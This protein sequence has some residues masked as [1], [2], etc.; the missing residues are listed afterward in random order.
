MLRCRLFPGR[1]HLAVTR[2]HEKEDTSSSL[3]T[4]HNPWEPPVNFENFLRN[5]EDLDNQ[6][7]DALGGRAGQSGDRQAEGGLSNLRAW[8]LHPVGSS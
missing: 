4:Q 6:V 7:K 1:Y 2:H 3:Y 8:D 5:N